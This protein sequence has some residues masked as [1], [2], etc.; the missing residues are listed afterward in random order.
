M[1]RKPVAGVQRAEMGGV[2]RPVHDPTLVLLHGWGFSGAVWAPLRAKL[3]AGT[4]VLAPDLPGHG[5]AGDGWRLADAEGAAA[6]LIAALPAD[7]ECPVWA[8]W[9]LGGLV[10]LA[11]ARQWTGPQ[12]LVLIGATPRFIRNDDWPAALPLDELEDF[13]AALGGDRRRL[14]RRLAMLCARGSPDAASLA[15]ALA[16][17]MREAPASPDGLAAGLD[18]LQG[19]DLRTAWAEVQAP[20]A[21]WLEPEDALVPAAVEAGLTSLRPDGRTGRGAGGH[22]DWWARP[23]RLAGFVSEFLD[24]CSAGESA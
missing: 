22:A 20:V 5:A 1:I 24:H 15:R 8:G 21:C 23:Q 19:A 3:P 10:A 11:A 9:S 13:R 2:T 16:D 6:A 14:N 4:R 17:R 7:V 18:L 12:G